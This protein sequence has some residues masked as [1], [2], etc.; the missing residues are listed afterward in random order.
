[1]S[2]KKK[3]WKEKR[4]SGKGTY[5][6]D[7]HCQNCGCYTWAYPISHLGENDWLSEDSKA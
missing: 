7:Y 3:E 4:K 2:R 6:L 5:S 1:V